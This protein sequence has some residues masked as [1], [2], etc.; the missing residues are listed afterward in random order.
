MTDPFLKLRIAVQT[1]KAS[2]HGPIGVAVSGGSDSLGLLYL[3]HDAGCPLEVATVDHGLRPE[4]AAEADYV[5]GLCQGLGL[6]HH[7]LAVDGIGA[8]GNLQDQARRARYRALGDWAEKQ[9]LR[10]VALGHTLDDQAETFLMRLARGAGIDGLSPLATRFELGQ[11]V[12]LRPLAWE[13]RTD[14]QAYLQHKGIKWIED[15]SNEDDR[16]DRV[17]AR[18]ALQVLAPLG[19]TVESLALSMGNLDQARQTLQNLAQDV[20]RTCI[21]DMSGDLVFDRTILACAGAETQRRLLVGMIL[22]LS[23]HGYPPRRDAVEELRQAIAHGRQITL[24]GCLLSHN[25]GESRLTREF[26]AVKDAVCPTDH[27]WDGRWVL[28]GP[29]NPGLTIRALGEAV[30]DTPWRDSGLP[31]R[32]L[33][34]SPAIWREDALVAAPMAGLANGWTAKAT[35]RGNFADFL[36]RR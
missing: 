24:A 30:T 9:S 32:S 8:T 20:A 4:A 7:V 29:H 23:G 25:D 14:L 12:F 26:N 5:T 21:R 22:F 3:L 27:L 33:L 11:T 10:Q 28:D 19:L 2:V 36:I 17:K 35:G 1:L 18:R 16:F 34:S 6:P 31:R 15:P 13:R